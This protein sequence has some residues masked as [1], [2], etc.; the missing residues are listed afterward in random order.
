MIENN[1]RTDINAFTSSLTT[2]LVRQLQNKRN[3]AFKRYIFSLVK[4]KKKLVHK[5]S[6]YIR[7]ELHHPV[8]TD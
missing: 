3:K 5:T 8:E 7:S 2:V 1:K 4:G 6:D